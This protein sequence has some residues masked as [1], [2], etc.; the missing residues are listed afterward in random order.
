M[1]AGWICDMCGGID[2]YKP[3]ECSICDNEMCTHCANY[4]L[5]IE[6]QKKEESGELYLKYDKYID[7]FGTNW[8]LKESE[9]KNE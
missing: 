6:C 1:K 5:C 2:S 7:D 3:M 8:K 9:D 4:Q